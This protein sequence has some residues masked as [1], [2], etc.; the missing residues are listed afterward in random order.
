MNVANCST[1]AYSY[2]TDT[3]NGF[4]QR[5]QDFKG[6]ADALQSGDI[7]AAQS[8]FSTLQTDLQNVQGNGKTPPILD[9]NTTL[10]KDFKALQDALQSGDVKA[11]QDAFATLKQDMRGVRHAHGHHHHR[12]DN[13]GDGDDGASNSA[14][15]ASDTSGTGSSQGNDSVLDTLA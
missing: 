3:H 8:A 2:P 5:M 4:R 15:S 11:A 14:T 13:D 7:S 9:E 6:L 10:G 12:V 1:A